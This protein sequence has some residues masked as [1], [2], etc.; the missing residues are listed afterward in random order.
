M[1]IHC[2]RAFNGIVHVLNLH[3]ALARQVKEYH[4]SLHTFQAGIARAL[5][6]HAE[7][8]RF[9]SGK[10]VKLLL[11]R[12]MVPWEIMLI[13]NGQAVQNI[14]AQRAV[15]APGGFEQFTQR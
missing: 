4:A 11:N 13:K 9:L 6:H 12:A 8:R 10:R 3:D 2:A 7:D 14:I 5:I 1:V 15:I